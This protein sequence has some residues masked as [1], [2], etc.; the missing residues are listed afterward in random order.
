MAG[1]R[2]IARIVALA[3]VLFASGSASA[4]LNDPNHETTTQAVSLTAAE[5]R[6][7]ISDDPT[8]GTKENPIKVGGG[9]MYMAAREVR[10]LS[11]LRGPS[12]E[13]IHFIRQGS[14]AGADERTFLDRYK[15]DVTGGKT[16]TLYIDAYHWDTPIAPQGLMCGVDMNLPP[17]GPDPVETTRTLWKLALG[18]PDSD[19]A[20]ISLD[21]D[22]SKT[23]GFV[24]DHVRLIAA[25]GRAAAAK[26]KPLDPMRL[27]DDLTRPRLIAIA[28]PRTCAG[29][30][31]TPKSIVI[32]DRN[33]NSPPVVERLDEAALA[34][35]VPGVVVP[36]HS[37]GIVYGAGSLIEG[38]RI[39]VEYSDRCSEDEPREV[40]LPVKVERARIL[41]SVAPVAPPDAV[42]P[43][44][45]A[46]VQ[47]QV[48]LTGDG[49]PRDP[50][51]M[52]GAWELREAAATAVRE[53]RMEPPRHNG[54]PVLQVSTVGV[55]VVK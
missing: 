18:L 22:G 34:K 2:D 5:S 15:L 9:V 29:A 52:A 24:F 33:G 41:R 37:I 50:V 3:L 35:R 17:P 51:F 46:Q 23:H 28:I 32:A 38:A 36:A 12:G 11:A 43:P 6:C 27:P 40:L 39:T 30:E 42:I 25:A 7:R 21:P 20:P 13:G 49:V 47:M 48:F 19:I 55:R 53:W 44:T 14:I 16:V 1:Q 31:Q 4:Q 8:Y 54:S 26:G 10:Y 45:G